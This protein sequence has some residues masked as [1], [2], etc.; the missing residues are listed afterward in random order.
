MWA[1]Y[2]FRIINDD[3]IC[4]LDI[5]NLFFGEKVSNAWNK[6]ISRRRPCGPNKNDYNDDDDD[7]DD[8]SG[9]GDDDRTGRHSIVVVGPS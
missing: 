8:K 5:E 7:D 2:V 3:R 4:K 9:D 6:K 1:N